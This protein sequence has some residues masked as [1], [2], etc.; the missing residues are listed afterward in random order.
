MP[1]DVVAEDHT[2]NIRSEKQRIRRIAMRPEI[3]ARQVR[4]ESMKARKH[5]AAFA[6]AATK[7]V[8][9]DR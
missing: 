9:R 1:G 3:L 4:D 8:Q 6:T 7:I 5:P 2:E